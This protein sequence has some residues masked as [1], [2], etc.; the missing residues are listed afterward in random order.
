MILWLIGMMGSGKSTVA[1][2]TASRLGVDSIDTD[3]MVERAAGMSIAEIWT[4]SGES[5]F[6]ALEKQIVVEAASHAGVIVATGGGAPIDSDSRALIDSVG[7]TVWLRATPEILGSR[8]GG[9]SERPLLD[10]GSSLIQVLSEL[11]DARQEVYAS[12]ADHVIET[13]RLTVDE[14]VDELE[15]IW[16]S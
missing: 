9:G 2:R 14:V 4:R 3:E 7:T 15:Q 12:V 16:K 11:V 5:G 1:V 6:R 8:L 13:D 10:S